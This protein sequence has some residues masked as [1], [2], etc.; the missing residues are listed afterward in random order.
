[1]TRAITVTI[2]DRIRHNRPTV[3]VLVDACVFY[4]L[5]IYFRERN[6]EFITERGYADAFSRFANW[7]PVRGHEFEDVDARCLLFNAFV[8][9]VRFG[10]LKLDEDPTGLWWRPTR[11]RTARLIS[12]RVIEVTD[13][14]DLYLGVPA[15][16]PRSRTASVAE[17]IRAWR[18]WDKRKS[19]AL[20]GHTRSAR[21]AAA[22][23]RRAA[24]I[25][26]PGAIPTRQPEAPAFP[27]DRIDDLLWV[28]FE[29]PRKSGDPRPW[30]RWN[31]RDILIT[32]LCLYGGLRES[33]P[34]HLWL[35]DINYPD[36]AVLMIF[37]QRV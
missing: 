34:L 12:Q 33:E 4:P 16:N 7:L 29:Y 21:Q 14:L 5:L 2:R 22:S 17:Q 35:D 18:R 8:H 30:V 11:S 31:L 3:V 23:V 9:D 1:M 37:T 28:G 15:V 32:L 24:R 13:W 25:A 27:D 19:S 10:T 26:F 20:L 36:R 6:L